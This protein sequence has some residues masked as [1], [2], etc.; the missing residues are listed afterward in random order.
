MRSDLEYDRY[1]RY[2]GF[3]RSKERADGGHPLQVFG[4]LQFETLE[5]FMNLSLVLSREP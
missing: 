2:D 1:D 4:R 5:K 3:D